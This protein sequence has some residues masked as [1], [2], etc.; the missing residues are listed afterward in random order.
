MQVG[1]I[2]ISK[3][4]CIGLDRLH[5]IVAARCDCA[6]AFRAVATSRY[7]ACRVKTS[8]DG[9]NVVAISTVR[10]SYAVR[11]AHAPELGGMARLFP[12][13]V[14]TS[15]PPH[16]QLE[17]ACSPEL[18]DVEP[19][20]AYSP[21]RWPPPSTHDTVSE[22]L[23]RW[24]RNPLGSARRGSNPLGVDLRTYSWASRAA[25]AHRRGI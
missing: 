12:I 7:G 17:R 21:R 25:A 19:I 14:V 10:H 13:V 1:L 3:V 5:A 2:R 6:A 23:R 20:F 24:T 15:P 11:C 18:R 22:R 9:A 8:D 4:F 16:C